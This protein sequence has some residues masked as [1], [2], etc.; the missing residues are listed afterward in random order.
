MKFSN[1]L[2]AYLSWKATG[3]KPDDFDDEPRNITEYWLQ[4]EANRLDSIEE[5]GGGGGVTDYNDLINKPIEP[6]NDEENLIANTYYYKPSH[7]GYL[8]TGDEVSSNGF[9]EMIFDRDKFVEKSADFTYPIT[10]TG[11][12]MQPLFLANSPIFDP[13]SP[14]NIVMYAGKTS[15]FGE[16]DEVLVVGGL[17][18]FLYASKHA[19]Q[20]ISL[21]G[22][23]HFDENGWLDTLNGEPFSIEA[24]LSSLAESADQAKIY[25]VDNVCNE[26]FVTKT[27]AQIFQY[28]D[29]INQS[30]V[31]SGKHLY[32]HQIYIQENVSQEISG[33]YYSRNLYVSFILQNTIENSMNIAAIY[34]FL[35]SFNS[36]ENVYREAYGISRGDD[37][38]TS[39]ITRIQTYD[40][41]NKNL[42]V[43]TPRDNMSKSWVIDSLA[44]CVD[45]VIPLI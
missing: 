16:E 15:Q 12:D 9:A 23:C 1:R 4:G 7:E 38:G 13:D 44:Y 29:G 43:W 40:E 5:G 31:P 36:S 2:E 17:F 41:N 26:A 37:S 30:L 14:Q 39:L 32:E 20:T 42:E 25:F 3:V 19:G 21:M 34:D 24:Y 27:E 35:K 28:K 22:T 45:K 10:G 18:Y 8:Q 6:Y 11:M 33:T